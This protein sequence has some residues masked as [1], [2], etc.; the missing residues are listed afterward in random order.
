MRFQNML[1]GMLSRKYILVFILYTAIFWSAFNYINYSKQKATPQT[2]SET[3]LQQVAK[4]VASPTPSVSATPLV[5]GSSITEK[6]KIVVPSPL[7]SNVPS[8]FENSTANN[9]ENTQQPTPTQTPSESITPQST[10]TPQQ[11]KLLTYV[12]IDGAGE[13]SIELEQGKNHCDVLS[14]AKNEGKLSS[15]TMKFFAG[16][17]SNAVY[18]INGLGDES[19]VWWTYEVNGKSPPYGCSQQQVQNND[20]VKWIY[21]GR[22]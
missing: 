19:Q 4:V 14:Q 11:L 20:H 21:V 12:S 9:T 18:E 2:I 5:L 3:V 8:S 15:L 22:R 7:P 16:F 10:P 13:F 17:S 6:K 1:R